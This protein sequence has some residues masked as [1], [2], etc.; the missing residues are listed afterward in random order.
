MPWVP[1]RRCENCR[2]WRYV[3]N[4]ETSTSPSEIQVDVDYPG[5]DEDG[6]VKAGECHRRAPAATAHG[7]MKKHDWPDNAEAV[8]PVTL[9]LDWCGE[10]EDAAS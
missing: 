7:A 1:P 8:W 3:P 4:D 5:K 6:Y 9:P 2:F 10:W